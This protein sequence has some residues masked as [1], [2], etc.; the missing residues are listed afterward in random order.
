MDTNFVAKISAIMN[1]FN[2]TIR[3]A[4]RMAKTAIPDEI[5][6][7]VTANINR[8]QRGILRAK[9][10]AQRWREHSVDIDGDSNQLLAVVARTKAKLAAWRKH[11]VKLDFD[12]SGMS[13]L[14]IAQRVTENIVSEYQSKMDR[15]AT[16]IRT[17]GTVFSQQIKGVMIASVQALI[18]VIAGLVPALFAVLNAMKVLS[19]GVIGLAGAFAVAG[20]GAIGF[21]AMAISAIK[22]LEDGLIEA[23]DAT[24]GYKDSLEE[25]KTTWQSIVKQNASNIFYA[26]EAGIRTVSSALDQMR[27]FLSGVS[28]LVELNARKMYDWVNNSNTAK[29]AFQALNTTGVQIFADLLN[30]AGRFGDGIVNVFTQFMPLF[31]WV[32]QGLQNMA[33]DFQNWANSV[34]GQ[35]AIKKFIEYTKT[36]LPKIG[37]IFG[38]VFGAIGNL[39]GAFAQN[40][41]G[42][43]DWLVQLTS[44]FKA[45]SEQVGK[46]EGFKKFVDYVEQNGPVI[47]KLIGDI[48]R[49]L[50]AFGTAM[51]PIASK[52]LS[53]IGAIAEFIAKLFEAHPNVAK[54]LGVLGILG[55]VFW[56]LMAPIIAVGTVLSNVFG[57]TILQLIGKIVRFAR[58]TT[59]MTT[60]MKLI[61][62]AFSL[63][64][65]PIANL[66]KLM[67]AL[68]GAFAAL[69]GPVGIIIGVIV[70]LVGA[71]IYLWNTNEDFRNFITEAWNGIFD[72]ISGAISSVMDWLSQL[73]QSIQATLQ[74]IM[75]VLQTLGE[76]FNKVL[77]VVVMAVINQVITAF[78]LLWTSIQI[79][80]QTIG[81][82]I[83]V[84]I[85]YWVGMFTAVIQFLS[86]D[87]SGAWETI[88]NTIGGILDTIWNHIKG[89]WDT[90]LSFLSSI[91]SRIFSMMGTSWSQIWSTIS[92]K[93]SKIWSTITSKFGALVGAIAGFVARWVAR[94]VSGMI[95]M[96]AQAVSGMARFVNAIVI[97]F[98]RFVAAIARGVLGGVNKARSF[99]GQFLSVGKDL[100]G[101]LIRGIINKAKELAQA[102]WNAAKG[103]LN[104]AKRALDSHSPS[105]EFMKL[106][107][108]SM[109]GMAIGINQYAIKAARASEAAANKVMDAFNL[110]FSNGLSTDLINGL[111]GS[112]VSD[113]D[114]HMSSDVRHSMAENNR[115]IV[116][117]T[118]KNEGDI[119]MI[120]SRIET[121][122]GRD[123]I[124]GL[125]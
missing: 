120:K 87:F 100:I 122:N 68:S 33:I 47:M 18:P 51:A 117:V 118:V 25:L 103:A 1:D 26:M 41:A 119:E 112:V 44:K 38:N 3:K 17:F 48:V 57:V 50:V 109:A 8:F 72:A 59:I 77:G 43:F 60:A 36:N 15:L 123:S 121:L 76:I 105:R 46:S 80:F 95:Q 125:S 113:V 7:E 9:S 71:V 62:G 31:K 29:K 75:P 13:K 32:S 89:V 5:T 14:K 4:Q 19:G 88:Q 82:I 21:R 69:T 67:P 111:G 94:V 49:V 81:T 101:G 97:G 107:N 65:S 61:K 12:T 74:P 63:L 16:S 102:A 2:R 124:I 70:A 110:D 39:M 58:S 34:S 92:N 27:P 91:M 83:S 106:G 40:S 73:W 45:W 84:A 104:A 115:P 28:S 22:M 20:V 116:N 64:M 35:N 6:T 37:Q 30:T 90:V 24:L 42:I 99:V 108:D 23:S 55:G 86:G 98:V 85:Q 93:V 56:A 52:L 66:T 54:F 78:Q 96:V 10:M 79:V 53:F 114:A 11:T